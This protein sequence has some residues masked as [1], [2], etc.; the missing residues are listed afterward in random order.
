MTS[1]Q[2]CDVIPFVSVIIYL[3]LSSTISRQTSV[4]P[5]HVGDA[6]LTW[7]P[8]SVVLSCYAGACEAQ[9]LAATTEYL[10]ATL[11][12]KYLRSLYLTLALSGCSIQPTFKLCAAPAALACSCLKWAYTRIPSGRSTCRRRPPL[13]DR[14]PASVRLQQTFPQ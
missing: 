4:L 2:W 10:L 12:K 9:V 14:V 5:G 11:L 13:G 3:C 7:R 6:D 8:W 1:S